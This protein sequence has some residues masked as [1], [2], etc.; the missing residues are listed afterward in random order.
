MYSAIEL[1]IAYSVLCQTGIEGGGKPENP[2]EDTPSNQQPPIHAEIG[3]WVVRH[4]PARLFSGHLAA[5]E[6]PLLGYRA[7]SSKAQT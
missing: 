1:S 7:K 4:Q 2:L 6:L 5:S 3:G